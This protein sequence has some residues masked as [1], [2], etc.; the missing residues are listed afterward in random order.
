MAKALYG[1]LGGADPVTANELVRLRRRVRELED[2]V[3]RLRAT[4]EALTA[5]VTE[6]RL[7]DVTVTAA[8]T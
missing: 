8:L 1:H 4:S 5:M 2:E 6:D 3:D 7:V